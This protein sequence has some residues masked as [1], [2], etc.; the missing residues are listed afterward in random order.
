[1]G[2]HYELGT[3]LVP[4]NSVPALAVLRKSG[5]YAQL[6]MIIVRKP[7]QSVCEMF[8]NQTSFHEANQR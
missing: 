6:K 2:V 8:E 4:K 1:M 3:L 7:H 5:F